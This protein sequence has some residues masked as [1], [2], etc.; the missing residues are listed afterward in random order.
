MKLTAIE[1]GAHLNQAYSQLVAL[2]FELAYQAP[3]LHQMAKELEPYL[4][5]VQ[6]KTESFLQEVYQF[7]QF[8]QEQAQEQSQAQQLVQ[9]EEQVEVLEQGQLQ[10]QELP[11]AQE[12]E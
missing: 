3:A 11:L 6:K 4:L 7:A 9:A 1:V 5:S 2:K 8:Q 10:A 12:K